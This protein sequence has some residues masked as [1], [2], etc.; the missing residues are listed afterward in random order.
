ML[1][2]ASC[3]ICFLYF[4]ASLDKLLFIQ[5]TISFNEQYPLKINTVEF[6]SNEMFLAHNYDSSSII[7]LL[8]VFVSAW[9]GPNVLALINLRPGGPASIKL[10][11]VEKKVVTM[12][13]SPEQRSIL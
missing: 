13:I 7:W 5:R 11:H 10:R 8:L 9:F 1:H 3:Y 2:S 6:C 12:E 4:L